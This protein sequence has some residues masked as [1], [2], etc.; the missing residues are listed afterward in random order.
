MSIIGYQAAYS[1]VVSAQMPKAQGC[2]MQVAG[3]ICKIVFLCWLFLFLLPAPLTATQ[4]YRLQ[5]LNPEGQP[6]EN[7]LVKH[8]KESSFTDVEGYVYLGSNTEKIRF[9]RLGYQD[10]SLKLSE[11]RNHQVIMQHLDITHPVIVVRE[12]EYRNPISA[13]D[14]QLIH[15]DT[16]APVGNSADLL[17]NASSFSTA[18]NRLVGERQTISLLG[19]FSRHTL[20]MLDGVALNAAG[21]AFDF[22]KI[23]VSQIERIEI[24]KG[25]A[26]S[27]GG[28][29]AIGGIV[30]IITKSLA[31]K[32]Q[33]DLHLGGSLGSYDLFK[34][35]YQL[36]LM[37]SSWALSMNYDHYYARNDFA[38]DAWWD[39][40]HEYRREHNA[41]TA[42]NLFVKAGYNAGAHQ[43]EYALSQGSFIR[44][45]PGPINFPD[46][47]D[48][49]RMNGIHWYHSLRYDWQKGDWENDLQLFH[50]SDESTYRNLESSN[51][52]HQNHYTQMQT[53]RG[54]QN[55]I[56][57]IVDQSK[58]EGSMELKT[59]D[60][61]FVEYNPDGSQKSSLRGDRNIVALALR[62]AQKYFFAGIEADT[63]LALRS[64]MVER[65]FHNTYRLEQLFSYDA[66]IKYRIGAN[67][68]TGFSL[69]SLYDMYWIGDS[70]THG[71]PDLKSESSVAYKIHAGLEHP[72]FSL[73]MAYYHN[74]ITDLIQWRQ[75]FLFGSSWKPFNVGRAQIRNYEA[76]A[77]WQM[78]ELLSFKAGITFSDA[79]DYS[80]ESNGNPSVTY[81]KYLTYTPRY[82]ALASLKL[83]DEIRAASLNWI[84]S[85][86]QYTTVDNLID[87][88][89]EFWTLDLELMHKFRI[90]ELSLVLSSNLKN[91]FNKRYEVY[92]YTPQPG[93]NWSCNLAL[94]YQFEL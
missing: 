33:G 18:D 51:P 87:P 94:E 63:R 75:I 47:Y 69:P 9:S 43:L 16:N 4:L 23:P 76:E 84:Y 73:N 3:A 89:P 36:S 92:A 78:H 58:L 37:R 74:E 55:T 44:H 19:S 25:N 85:A 79:R 8:A 83:A 12:L 42:D 64:D 57:R 40:E 34:Q 66:G 39:P 54:L 81:G 56:Y 61:H 91:L 2:F 52:I 59:L 6:L 86:E 50:Q 88:L 29:A 14:A 62:A 49:S 1:P 60:S 17:L 68:A 90:K 45:L 22:S 13:L 28:S 5:V 32:Q 48:A 80:K 11:I 26:S 38:Y 10:L 82:K 21:E 72:A 31:R 77:F 67:Y 93:F 65:D 35:Q 71:N 46:L 30:N 7:V 20:V 70:E 27:Y 24:L 15:P 53:H 41:K